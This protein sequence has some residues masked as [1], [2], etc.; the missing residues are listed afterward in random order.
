MKRKAYIINK[1]LDRCLGA[2]CNPSTWEVEARSSKVQ[3][4]VAWEIEANVCY[5]EP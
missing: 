1:Y 3:G 5:M 2:S 4:S